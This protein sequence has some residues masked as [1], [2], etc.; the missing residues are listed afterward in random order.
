MT[1]LATIG[2][3]LALAA[4][5][6]R[7]E[8][9]NAEAAPAP[10]GEDARAP[11]G[12]GVTII[13]GSRHLMGTE[14]GVSVAGVPEDQARAAIEAALD[15]VEEAEHR[16]SPF[17]DDS[18]V[19]KINQAA[20][21]SAVKVDDAT[22]E[23]LERARQVSELSGGAFDVTFAALSPVWRSLRETPP[24]VPADQDIEAARALVDYRRLVLDRAARTAFLAGA[25]MRIDL[26]GIGQGHGADLAGEALLARG[27]RDFIVDG[28]GDLLIHG[29]KHGAPWKIGIQHPRRRGRTELIG[30]LTFDGD[31]AMVTSGDYERFVEIDG[32][33]Y[34]HIFDPRTGRPARGCIS[35]TLTAPDAT[36]ADG[37]STAVFVMGPVEGMRLVERLDGVEAVIIDEQMNITVSEGLR[38]RVRLREKL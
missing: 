21:V 1:R 23:V 15:A 10:R 32:V 9:A 7:R 11:D 22:F 19:T 25:G 35:V 4:C 37:L 6:P 33:R 26:G 12:G 2:V 18:V 34:H 27:V 5:H 16:L 24:R 13:E 30:H 29:S 8:E 14:F 17:R 38:D 36:L 28:G 3:A 31:Q 20:G